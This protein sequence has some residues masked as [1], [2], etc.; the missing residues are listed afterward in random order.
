MPQGAGSPAGCAASPAP[1]G[2]EA[3]A[4][5]SSNG[6]PGSAEG[7]AAPQRR[8]SAGLEDLQSPH[9]LPA[10][11]LRIADPRRYFERAKEP[12]AGGGA[13][14]S[15]GGA[16]GGLAGLGTALAGV[17]GEALPQP[18]VAPEV[19]RAVLLAA[20]P[21]WRAMEEEAMHGVGRKPALQGIAPPGAGLH[22]GRGGRLWPQASARHLRLCPEPRAGPTAT[23]PAPE[24]AGPALRDPAACLAAQDLVR[25]RGLAV[26][27]NELCRLFWRSLPVATPARRAK[28][29]HTQSRTLRPFPR[30]APPG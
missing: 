3:G 7:A 26:T 28:V 20:T 27:V 1:A 8:R 15:E 6:A 23:S 30:S 16:Q 21:L 29:C 11:Q 14:W 25:L 12:A 22:S 2:A 18:P 19:A 10:E 5:P 9:R 24:T 13:G 4:G 17:S